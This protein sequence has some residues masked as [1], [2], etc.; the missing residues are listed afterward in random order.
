MEFFDYW[1]SNLLYSIFIIFVII[2]KFILYKFIL[3][4]IN[5][6]IKKMLYSYKIIVKT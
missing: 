1:N 6:R 3:E 4:L 5:K 2:Q